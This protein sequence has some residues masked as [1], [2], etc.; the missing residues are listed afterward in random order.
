MEYYYTAIT[1][2]LNTKPWNEG[3]ITS[4][5]KYTQQLAALASKFNC[6]VDSVVGYEL[7]KQCQLHVHTTLVSTKILH[8]VS[9]C[10]WYRRTY[11]KYSIWLVPV[12]SLSNWKDYCLKTGNDEEKY[13]WLCRFYSNNYPD[14]FNDE[15]AIRNIWHKRFHLA[16]V[17]LNKVNHW[18]KCE[19]EAIYI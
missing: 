13:H 16:D 15:E 14:E 6:T 4:R 18:E 2:K 3:G 7:D 12:S 5:E 17:K 1:L 10:K 9:I 19:I 8:R 11:E